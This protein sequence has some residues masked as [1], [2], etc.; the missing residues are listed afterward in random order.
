MVKLVEKVPDLDKVFS[1][2]L[3]QEEMLDLEEWWIKD[4]GLLTGSRNKDDII[5]VDTVGDRV[6]Q[7]VFS[8][9]ILEQYDGTANYTQLAL[10]KQTLKQINE[11]H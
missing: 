1:Y 4:L 9:V 10:L 6:D 2:I 3:C 5:V 7:E 8:S 11:S